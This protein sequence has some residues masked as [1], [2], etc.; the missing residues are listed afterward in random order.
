MTKSES[1][2]AR[3]VPTRFVVVTDRVL[4]PE[5]PVRVDLRAV[6]VFF[7]HDRNRLGAELD[8]AQAVELAVGDRVAGHEPPQ[9]GKELRGERARPLDRARLPEER[10]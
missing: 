9:K 10:E 6:V 4:V 5:A 7:F 1:F 3:E 8:L 2:R